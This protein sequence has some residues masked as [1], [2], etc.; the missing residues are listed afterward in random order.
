[1]ST[2]NPK[3][4]DDRARRRRR[5]AALCDTLLAS[6]SRV[7]GLAAR[8]AFCIAVCAATLPYSPWIPPLAWLA[9]MAVLALAEHR[10]LPP[11][12]TLFSWLQSAGY[13]AAA[14]YLTFFE[15]GAAQTFGVTLF[16]VVMFEI[17]VRD[18]ARPRRLA[19]NMSPMVAAMLLVQTVAAVFLIRANQPWRLA[20]VL[21]TTYVVFRALRAVQV[22]LHRARRDLAEAEARAQADARTIREA[23]RIALMAET[24]AGVG[25]WR[26]DIASGVITW[27]EG[28]FRIFGLEP[29]SVAPGLTEQLTFF[30]PS[31]RDALETQFRSAAVTGESFETSLRLTRADGALRHVVCHGAAE[32]G[33]DGQVE[34]L[35]GAVMDVTEAHAREAALLDAK[36]QAEAAAEAK[37]EFLAN[38]SHEIRTPLTAINGFTALLGELDDLPPTADAYVRRVDTA[39]QALLAVVNDILDFSK[40]EAGHVALSPAPF[41]LEPFLD[42]LAA[43]FAEQA[44]AKG[45]GLVAEID[46]GAP[47]VLSADAGRLSQIAVNLLGNAV[48]FTEAGEVRISA[49]FRDGLL[50]VAVSDTGCG[51]PA[52]K[53]ERLFQRFSQVD[54][55]HTRRHG[56]TGLGLSICKGLV[57][58]MGGDI[59]MVPADGG[60]SVFRFHVRAAPADLAASDAP[61]RAAAVEGPAAQVLVVDDV[62]A[63][64]ELVRAM[65]QAI[66]H[67]VIEAAS[68]AEA[69]LMAS[70]RPFDLILMD[71]QMPGMDGFAAARAI[72]G[73]ISA[74]RQT[75]IIALSADVLP[76]HVGATAAAGMNGHIGKPISA[77]ELIGAVERWSGV[78]LE[79]AEAELAEA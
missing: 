3:D 35:F 16:G 64:R 52:D 22:D 50:H 76:E 45:L 53:R 66:G 31:E 47:A 49:A 6:P 18:Y 79:A 26:A 9:V 27:S 60:G 4:H 56:G 77:M 39:G 68:G 46:P 74:N 43:M 1:M 29:A 30:D 58:L 24:M 75:P 48:K 42:D 21:A 10:N 7:N 5:L 13:A 51:V 25:H 20:T 73:P 37:A 69:V 38:M 70:D 8:L 11:G 2:V 23:H 19:I 34:T 62:D 44:R 59:D 32:L 36:L 15:T 17:V 63:N 12:R 78:R 67:E 14:F 72:R 28:V 61:A 41:A 55:S 54:G 65:L 57:E 71:L 40:L 33:P